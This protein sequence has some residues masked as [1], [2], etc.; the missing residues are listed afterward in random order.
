M[1]TAGRAVVK[2]RPHTAG[3]SCVTT[4]TEAET[5]ISHTVCPRMSAE[6]E[7]GWRQDYQVES[8]LC[9][10]TEGA[11]VVIEL[12]TVCMCEG[13]AGIPSPEKGPHLPT[14]FRFPLTLRCSQESA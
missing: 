3:D 7:G 9:R 2:R 13:A 8:H 11:F 1:P 14:A 10:F 6:E 12:A 5:G 4:V